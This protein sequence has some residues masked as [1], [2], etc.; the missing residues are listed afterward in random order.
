VQLAVAAGGVVIGQL[1]AVQ[2][3]LAGLQMGEGIDE[4]RIG[5]HHGQQHCLGVV[6]EELAQTDP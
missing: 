6:N 1:V 2:P 5:A 3:V 4:A